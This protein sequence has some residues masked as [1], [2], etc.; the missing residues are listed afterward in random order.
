MLGVG[1]KFP[2]FNLKAVDVDNTIKIINSASYNGKWA[3]FFFWPYD[4]TFICPTEIQAFGALKPEFDK[5]NAQ[6]LGVSTDSEHV[7][8]N[9]K[10]HD[11]RIASLPFPML[12]DVSRNLVDA[13]GIVDPDEAV[14]Q[15]ATYIVDPDK[16][17]RYVSVTDMSVGRN[18]EECLRILKA[19]QNGGLCP[20]NWQEGQSTL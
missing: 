8:L 4:F 19:S 13:L 9:W 20:V 17:I 14:A 5:H 11:D 16:K 15:R 12:A 2:E 1:K 7:H 3:V 18:T 10:K 6:I